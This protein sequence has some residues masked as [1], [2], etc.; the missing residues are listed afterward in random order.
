M[1]LLVEMIDA[2]YYSRVTFDQFHRWLRIAE[3]DAT[4]RQPL[5]ALL[6]ELARAADEVASLEHY[7]ETWRGEP[8]APLSVLDEVLSVLRWKG[9]VDGRD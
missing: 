1:D 9:S 3:R 5:A 2:P 7:L 6:V 4:M 8:K